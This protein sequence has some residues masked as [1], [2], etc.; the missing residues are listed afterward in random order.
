MADGPNRPR[1][2]SYRERSR[3]SIRPLVVVGYLTDASVGQW[4][5]G[6]IAAVFTVVDT[7]AMCLS[8]GVF[9]RS[10]AAYSASSNL[11]FATD[12]L[13][14]FSNRSQAKSNMPLDSH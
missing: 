12:V 7:S 11:A 10:P 13:F 4:L 8:V 6:I 1:L 9:V 14:G 3:L 5:A 2:I